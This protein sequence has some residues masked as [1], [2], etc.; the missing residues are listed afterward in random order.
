M[1]SNA[2]GTVIRIVGI[3]LTLTAFWYGSVA[4][5]YFISCLVF[6][7][8]FSFKITLLLFGSLL[9]FKMFYPKNVFR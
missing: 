4:I 6:N 7:L 9:I 3:F 5:L 2:I 1:S 8:N